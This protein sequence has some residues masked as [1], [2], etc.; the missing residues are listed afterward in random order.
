MTHWPTEYQGNKLGGPLPGIRLFHG[1]YTEF[2]REIA[3]MVEGGAKEPFVGVTT[4]G[5]V[6]PGVYEFKNSGLDVKPHVDAAL[7]FLD[8]IDQKDTRI[9]VQ[10][11]FDSWQRRNWFN[12]MPLTF[13]EGILLDDLRPEQRERALEVV[14]PC[15]SKDGFD[16]LR[17][18]MRTNEAMGGIINM[19]VDSL[20]EFACWL[21]IWGEPNTDGQP[22]GWQLM[23]LHIDI[24]VTF[25]G[26]QIVM[27][28]MFMGAEWNHIDQGPFAGIEVYK[29]EENA[30][31]ALGRTLTPEQR[32]KAVLYPSMH[33]HDLPPELAGPVDGRHIAGAGRD[34]RVMP[35]EGIGAAELSDEQR[36]LLIALLDVYLSRWAD[37]W[38]ELRREEIMR[39]LDETWVAYIGE[40]TE[41]PFYY[42]IHSPSVVIE[43]DHHPALAFESMDVTTLHVHTIMRQPNGGDYGMELI[44]QRDAAST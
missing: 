2:P 7:A 34:N 16:L 37:G 8:C 39:F 10:R 40:P 15:M 41:T 33:A 44:R 11:P 6:R 27:E 3:E 4:D 22:W 1:Y 35:Y 32:E 17:D 38:R 14:R 12:A 25:V 9:F 19:Y 23:G 21:T 36:E 5:T 28:P 13:P 43:F 30:A 24:N 29:P 42:R 18:T 26:D 20:T 31:L